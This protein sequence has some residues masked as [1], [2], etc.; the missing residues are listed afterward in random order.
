MRL[1]E[2]IIIEEKWRVGTINNYFLQWMIKV[3]TYLY[4]ET[5]DHLVLIN[6]ILLK[7]S[8]YVMCYGSEQGEVGMPPK[9]TET[10][11]IYCT[12]VCDEIREAKCTWISLKCLNYFFCLLLRRQNILNVYIIFLHSFTCGFQYEIMYRSIDHFMLKVNKP[13]DSKNQN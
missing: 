3:V 5:W 13:C 2:F 4:G 1:W 9:C 6:C 8:N 7:E 12:L 11:R 10:T